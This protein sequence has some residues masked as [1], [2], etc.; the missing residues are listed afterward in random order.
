[1]FKETK[2]N[3]NFNE[4]IDN[5]F[6]DFIKKYSKISKEITKLRESIKTE[7]N[8]YLNE[9]QNKNLELISIYTYSIE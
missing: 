4:K 9:S 3:L 6:S 7:Y 5:I 1:M 8:I 2:Y